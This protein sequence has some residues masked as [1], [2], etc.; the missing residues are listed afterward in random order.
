MGPIF[1]ACWDSARK[2]RESHKSG[3]YKS[4][5]MALDGS[6]E[7]KCYIACRSDGATDL[8]G[9]LKAILLLEWNQFSN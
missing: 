7:L 1:F 2:L 6:P 5:M 9:T 4:P 8:T 3:V